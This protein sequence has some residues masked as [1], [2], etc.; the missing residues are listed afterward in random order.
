MPNQRIPK[1]ALFGWLPEPCPPGGPRKRRRDQIRQDLKSVGISEEDWYEEASNRADWRAIYHQGLQDQYSQQEVPTQSQVHCQVCGRSF[2][3]QRPV[4]EQRGAVQCPICSRWFHSQWDEL[5]IDVTLL[6][7]Q[8]PADQ[9]PADQ[10]PGHE[11]SDRT[12]LNRTD[13]YSARS[14][15]AGSREQAT[16]PGISVPLRER[17][18]QEQRGAVQ[19]TTCERWFLSQGGLAVHRCE[20]NI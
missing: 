16:K 19:C 10:T 18:V 3:H 13:R 20:P 9:T 5:S 2:R 1:M 11:V 14:A 7:P 15:C 8:T 6:I 12:P 4:C 17:P